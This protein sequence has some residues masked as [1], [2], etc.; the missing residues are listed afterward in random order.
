[1]RKG[2]VR[3]SEHEGALSQDATYTRVARCIY[4]GNTRLYDTTS[5]YWNEEKQQSLNFKFMREECNCQ[6]C[7]EKRS[8]RARLKAALERDECSDGLAAM[9]WI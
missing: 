8:S 7:E 2:D 4:S 3:M 1:M 9:G 6:E 5:K